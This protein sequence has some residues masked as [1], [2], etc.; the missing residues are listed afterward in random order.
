[1]VYLPMVGPQPR[2]WAV[3]SPAYV[4][5]SS[6]AEL[7]A[8]DIRQ[9]LRQYAPEAPMYRLFTMEGLADRAL[10]QLSFTTL[11]LAI[12]SGLALVLGAVGLYGVLSYVVSQRVREIAVR[13][14]LGAE[15]GAVRRMV[16]WQGAR[17]ALIGVAVGILAALGVTG[18]LKS[19]LFRV[20]ELDMTTF[21]VMSAVMLVVA[22][23]ASYIPA[24]RASAVDPVEA[25]RGE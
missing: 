17:V 5:K 14:A 24:Y 2:S 18:V 21:T 8:P 4:V 6:R 16:V 10:A 3:G 11:M 23:I 9:I 13:I 7:L 1:M 19:L 12:A 22:I 20:Q 15:T 25:L